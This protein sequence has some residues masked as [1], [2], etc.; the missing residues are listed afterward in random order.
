VAVSPDM[1]S[2]PADAPPPG[3]ATGP[4]KADPAPPGRLTRRG[5]L[6]AAASLVLVVAGHRSVLA[7]PRGDR[8]LALYNPNTDERFDDVYWCDGSYVADSLKRIDWLMR[9]FHRDAVAPIDPDLIELLQRIACRLETD[10]PFSLLSGYR[11]VAT[12]RLLRREG[13]SVAV[14]SEHLKGKAADIRV[15]G[16]SLAHLRR[17]AVSLRAGGVGSYPRDHFVHVDVGPLR[18]W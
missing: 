13:L 3:N 11:T 6:A 17:A 2:E 5:L 8:R 16:V 10:K 18:V 7:A 12:N 9:D 15:D 4:A 14:H 1:M